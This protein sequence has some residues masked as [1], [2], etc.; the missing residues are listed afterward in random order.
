MFNVGMIGPLLDKSLIVQQRSFF[1]ITMPTL[2]NEIY[3]YGNDGCLRHIQLH[4][5]MVNLNLL[6][7][8]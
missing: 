2:E 5:H 3:D 1:A 4:D 6:F 7:L 8:P